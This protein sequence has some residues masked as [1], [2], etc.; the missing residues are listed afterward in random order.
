MILIEMYASA[1]FQSRIIYCTSRKDYG[2]KFMLILKRLKYIVEIFPVMSIIL[3][4]GNLDALM[5]G[6]VVFGADDLA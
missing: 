6:F 5:K 2:I 3:L 4:A 1:C